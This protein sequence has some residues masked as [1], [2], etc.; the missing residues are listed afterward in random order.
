MG[1]IQRAH[2]H[3]YFPAFEGLAKGRRTGRRY[4]EALQSQWLPRGGA[5]EPKLRSIYFM[6][7]VR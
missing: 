5:L 7:H 2:E 3:L 4:W 1:W 6:L